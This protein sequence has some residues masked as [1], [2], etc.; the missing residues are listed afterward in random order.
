MTLPNVNEWMTSLSSL[1][2]L[3][4]PRHPRENVCNNDGAGSGEELPV[5][6]A[7][8][9]EQRDD[10][11]TTNIDDKSTFALKRSGT[12]KTPPMIYRRPQSTAH[13]LHS[14]SA[15]R[16]GSRSI[17]MS[18]DKGGVTSSA[19]GCN[20]DNDSIVATAAALASGRV[21][22]SGTNAYHRRQRSL[23]R[24]DHDNKSPASGSNASP[25][26]ASGKQKTSSNLSSDLLSTGNKSY[27]DP[28]IA[29]PPM[30]M[31][32]T[33]RV[34]PRTL[35]QPTI[36]HSAA[37]DLWIATI[38]TDASST[39]SANESS[40]N[41]AKGKRMAFSFHDEKAARASAYANSPPVPVPFGNTS[42]CML[43]DT[44]FTFLR[45]PKHCKN[46][47]IVI[48]AECSTRWNMKMLPETYTNKSTLGLGKTVRVCVSCDAV[49]KRFKHA[50]ILGR[51]DM[52]L[53]GYLTGN[54]N[55]RCPFV[56][57]GEKEIM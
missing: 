50:L 2:I 22:A 19:N 52:A 47:G 51:Y 17:G 37:T 25:S 13:E 54:V 5:P 42:Q 1:Q 27:K 34:Y 39:S 10:A 21:S 44:S 24:N 55:L 14:N 30:I 11:N 4:P 40:K 43:C 7:C 38:H 8:Y 6:V 46:C 53:E 15:I 35:M 23:S 28:N 48:C 3:P 18:D 33:Q 16:N 45:R 20:A 26:T 57:K 29:S 31:I 12:Q 49:A 41:D 32:G 36:H 9:E 56:F